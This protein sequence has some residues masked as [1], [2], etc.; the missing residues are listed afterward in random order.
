MGYPSSS[1]RPARA[2]PLWTRADVAQSVLNG[3]ALFIRHGLV[4]RVPSGWLD[5]HPGGSLSIL[6]CVGR[7]VS[8]ETDAFHSDGV[9]ALMDKYAVA[10]V[11]LGE[12]GWAPLVPPFAS[13]WLRRA[14]R[15]VRIATAVREG[16]E[17]LLFADRPGP[18]VAHNGPTLDDL[19]PAP[20][21][22][23]ACEQHRLSLGYQQLHQR[24]QD[25]GL[26]QTRYLAGYGPEILR[27]ILL[28]TLS[29]IA[30]RSGW[31]LT[32]AVFLGC[33]WHQLS[34]T[35]H[36]LGHMGVTHSWTLDRIL[37]VLV[38]D[39]MGG[40]SVGWWV[41]N[42]NVHHIVTNHPS[43]DPD[44]EHIPFF[45]VSTHFLRSLHSSY[46]NSTMFFDTPARIILAIQDKLFYIVMAFARFNLAALS[47]GF[48]WRTRPFL[49]SGMQKD[50]V[51]GTTARRW[52]FAWTA[53]V[54]CIILF[55]N[56]YA[57]VLIG[58]GSWRTALLSLVISNVVA[59][60]LHV[61]IVLSHFSRSTQ[62]LGPLESFPHRQLRTTVDVACPDWLAFFHGGLHLQVT[63]HF[64][65]RLPRHNLRAASKLVRAFAA[66][67]GLEYAEFGF[68]AGNM[69]VLGVLRDV[70]NQVAFVGKVAQAEVD[71][72]LAKVRSDVITTRN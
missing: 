41:D 22:L 67:H 58:T 8:N 63:H 61:Q 19:E 17:I 47:Y 44:I 51:R 9:Q 55:W 71:E 36:D 50:V 72:A 69:D 2:L 62:D 54:L 4:I 24:V 34:F 30:Y 37:G 15:W 64:F 49:N 35:V 56:W 68:A 20:S 65:P 32:S 45:A 27:Y 5:K 59:S 12:N 18:D 28:A 7:D 1:G 25:A 13:G 26:Y 42:H 31:F 60:P 11:E 21:P 53:E 6:H 14:G 33:L 10:R 43:H 29:A 52:T 66:E 48:L 39:V 57:R 40:L 3:D 46:Y 38:A 70:A 16:S 23:D